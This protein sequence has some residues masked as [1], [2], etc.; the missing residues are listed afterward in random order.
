MFERIAQTEAEK[1]AEALIGRSA[2]QI[3]ALRLAALLLIVN[4]LVTATVVI[5]LKGTIPLVSI[6]I[7]LGL[8]FYLYKL[9]PRAEA[10]ALGLTI[11][12]AV[13]QVLLVL[14]NTLR[15][16][17]PPGPAFATALI[18]SVPGWATTG[19]LFLLLIGSPSRGRGVAAL[20][21]Y[22]VFTVGF[23]VL[24]I[25]GAFSETAAG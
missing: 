19:A 9:R 3:A 4:A 20:A 11:F 23:Y 5:L 17:A 16:N 13:V 22:L 15:G 12:A 2:D 8:A 10:L 14:G 24:V 25:V 6:A 7:S 21:L 18:E 1:D